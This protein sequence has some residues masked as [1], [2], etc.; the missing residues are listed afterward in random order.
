MQKHLLGSLR[1][2]FGHT[3]LL[4]VCRRR[5]APAPSRARPGG[6]ATRSIPA[7]P[8]SRFRLHAGLR[9][10]G[11]HKRAF[12]AGY[13]RVALHFLSLFAHLHCPSPFSCFLSSF[14]VFSHCLL[15]ISLLFSSVCLGP[16]ARR[17]SRSDPTS[18]GVAPNSTPAP[19][20]T[21]SHGP[22][23]GSPLDGG[24]VSHLTACCAFRMSELFLLLTYVRS[25]PSS[26]HH[27]TFSALTH[28]FLLPS[29]VRSLLP[30]PSFRYPPLSFVSPL[31][32]KSL[33]LSLSFFPVF[34]ITTLAGCSI[35]SLFI[36]VRVS[37]LPSRRQG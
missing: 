27:F 6:T 10:V 28:P 37:H 14:N 2:H 20:Q 19:K 26:P 7:G 25:F 23:L 34:F 35:T 22:G 9:D 17:R 8:P 5:L 3:T 18:P 4:L 1:S 36:L 21:K 15:L 32:W 16:T 24:R 30:D 11:R 31:V 29:F 33:V 12:A 13:V